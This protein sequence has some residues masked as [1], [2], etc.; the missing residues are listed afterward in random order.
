MGLLFM[1]ELLVIDIQIQNPAQKRI[2]LLFNLQI[3]DI[4]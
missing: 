1:T 2:A 3:H 4:K